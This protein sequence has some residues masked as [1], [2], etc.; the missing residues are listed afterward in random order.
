M[1]ETRSW[2]NP[3]SVIGINI[4]EQERSLDSKTITSPKI[5]TASVSVSKPQAQQGFCFCLATALWSPMQ[6]QRMTL[7]IILIW[8][9]IRC[10]VKNAKGVFLNLLLLQSLRFT[11]HHPKNWEHFRDTPRTITGKD[12]ASPGF[13]HLRYKWDTR[14]PSELVAFWKR[15]TVLQGSRHH[16]NCFWGKSRHNR[17]CV[18]DDGTDGVVIQWV[19]LMDSWRIAVLGGAYRGRL[20]SVNWKNVWWETKK[21]TVRSL[22]AK[23]VLKIHSFW[24]IRSTRESGNQTGL[25]TRENP[26]WIVHSF[27]AFLQP[28]YLF[29][30]FAAR[31]CVHSVVTERKMAILQNGFSH[32]SFPPSVPVKRQV[33]IIILP[34]KS[35]GKSHDREL[36]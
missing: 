35:S 7:T 3:Q 1:E 11:N 31:H 26:L 17:H 25:E 29:T 32:L 14:I 20:P 8:S 23:L 28:L 22:R 5:W 6:F 12:L 15:Y 4:P 36:S 21:S 24:S 19:V 18:L 27:L 13:H 2:G 10:R 30:F 33:L 16:I 34:N 9:R